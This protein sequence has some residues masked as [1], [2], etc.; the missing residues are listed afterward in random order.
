MAAGRSLNVSSVNYFSSRRGR[1]VETR[2]KQIWGSGGSLEPPGPLPMHL[3]TV[4]M[5]C[6][7]CVPTRLNP[8]A[9]RTCFSQVETFAA[10]T[11]DYAEHAA[12]APA[13]V[14][15]ELGENHATVR[16]ALAG[17]L[18]CPWRVHA[19]RRACS[20]SDLYGR[21]CMGARGAA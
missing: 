19:T 4:Y 5:A 16:R 14:A 8:L 20:R 7:E 10:N 17:A 12:M 1:D 9:E 18:K 3:H 11:R 15:R 6:S 2:E 21:V 13:D